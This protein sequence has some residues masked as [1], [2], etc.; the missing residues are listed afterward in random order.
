MRSVSQPPL[1]KEIEKDRTR[2]GVWNLMVRGLC[3]FQLVVLTHVVH[4]IAP[5]YTLFES[6]CYW[7]ANVIF[8]VILLLFPLKLRTSPPPGSS[9][10]VHLPDKYLLKEAGQWFGVLIN[11]PCVVSAIVTIAKLNSRVNWQST[12]KR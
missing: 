5:T 6:Q 7:Y 3:L 4:K 11:N 12:S 1:Q 8:E 2:T 10:T 9:P